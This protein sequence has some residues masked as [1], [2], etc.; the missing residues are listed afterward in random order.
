MLRR[1]QHDT[2]AVTNSDLTQERLDRSIAPYASVNAARERVIVAF[3]SEAADAGLFDGRTVAV[4]AT[5]AF[6][7]ATDVAIPALNEAGVDVE[8]EALIQGEGTVGG[9]GAELAVN[10]E[11]MRARGVYAVVIV[12]D[13][14]VPVN[15]FIGEGFFPRLFFT[16]QGGTTRRSA[17]P[18]RSSGSSRSRA[19]TQRRSA[20]ASTTPR[21]ISGWRSTT[22]TPPT[23][24]PT[25]SNSPAD[26]CPSRS[27][28]ARPQHHV[29]EASRIG[30]P[31]NRSRRRH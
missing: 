3:T 26:L 16:D 5:D 20:G 31:K 29:R 23:T 6:H 12:G 14:N 8:F 9:A 18:S 11:F 24:R 15:T 10:V 1:E 22:P 7:V 27:A 28:A 21:T 13:A 25:S 17:R 4:L 19:P 2:I 30:P